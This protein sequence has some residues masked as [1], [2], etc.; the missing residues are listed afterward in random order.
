MLCG[1]P[2]NKNRTQNDNPPQRTARACKTHSPASLQLGAQRSCKGCCRERSEGVGSHIYIYIHIH[3]YI[4]KAI[5]C[6]TCICKCI[7]ICIGNIHT[8]RQTGRQTYRQT[9]IHYIHCMH[10]IHYIAC[11]HACINTVCI[12]IYICTHDAMNLKPQ[13][14][15]WTLEVMSVSQHLHV[16]CT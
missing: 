1:D 16:P 5:L 4:D 11:M 14:L 6:I 3:V 15:V 7:C 2:C 12:Y 13:A 9:Y 10:Y 8:Y